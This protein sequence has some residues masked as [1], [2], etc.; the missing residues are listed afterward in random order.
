MDLR[1]ILV[2]LVVLA[3]PNAVLAQWWNPFAPKS[4]EECVVL[5]GKTAQT[6]MAMKF[7]IRECVA[8]FSSAQEPPK[9][10]ERKKCLLR[11]DERSR[12]LSRITAEPTDASNL[13][14]MSIPFS[15]RVAYVE[16]L[17]R[18]LIAADKKKKNSELVKAIAREYRAN[19]ILIFYN[20]SLDR[21][22]IELIFNNRNGETLCDR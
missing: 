22:F 6:D 8:K 7:V 10:A 12:I 16:E 15:D 20:K 1:L 4:V 21:D 13:R 3:F 14:G 5:G 19:T 18:Q 11:F 17:A 9:I 2:A